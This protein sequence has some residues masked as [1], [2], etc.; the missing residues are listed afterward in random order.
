MMQPKFKDFLKEFEGYTITNVVTK[1][2]D[3]Y[4]S[5][6]PVDHTLVHMELKDSQDNFKEV[7]LRVVDYQ[8][9]EKIMRII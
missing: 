4:Q 8:G 6:Y 7:D 9:R 1:E 3:E 5:K 2:R